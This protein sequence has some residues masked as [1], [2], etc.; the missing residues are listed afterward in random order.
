M[1]TVPR[2]ALEPSV[3]A[4]L[5]RSVRRIM[6]MVRRYF[7]LLRSSRPRVVELAYWPTMLMILWGF[8]HQF[9]ITNSNWVAKAGGILIGAILLWDVIFRGNLGVSVPFLEEMWSRNLG[10]LFG[11]PLR[12]HEWAIALLSISLIRTVVGILPAAFLAIP[13]YH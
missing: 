13:L 10:Q 3:P 7:Y 11:S 8:I 9:L 5:L 1:K 12:P 6:A 4:A 2:G